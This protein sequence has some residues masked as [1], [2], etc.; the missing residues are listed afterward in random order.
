MVKGWSQRRACALVGLSRGSYGGRPANEKDEPVQEAL[1]VLS[2]RH[3]GG[4][5]WKLHH[6]LRKNGL[7]INHKCTWCLYQAMGLHLPRR[8]KKRVPARVK[9]PLVMP[10]AANRCWALDFTSDVLTDGRRFRT[11]NALDAFNRQLL[12]VEI[13]F[14]V[15]GCPRGAGADPLSRVP[16]P[17]RAVA[18]R[19]WPRIHQRPPE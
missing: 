2:V 15:A 13:G 19:Q 3:P 6:R 5:F 7:I 17:S 10:E 18:H 9:Q 14:F 8:L 11:L 16:W 12:G 4:G 1:R